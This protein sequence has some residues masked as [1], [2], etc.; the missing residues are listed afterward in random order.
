MLS[1]FL[2]R[3]ASRVGSAA[4]LFLA[5][6]AGVRAEPE[7]RT[8]LSVDFAGNELLTDAYLAG[9]VRLGPGVPFRE[10][11]LDAAVKDLY[12]VG[13]TQIRREIAEEPEGVRVTLH[14]TETAVLDAARQVGCPERIWKS[15][16]EESGLESGRFVYRTDI[17]E[18]ERRIV[19]ELGDRRYYKASVREEI[20]SSPRGILVTFHV[21]TGPKGRVVS[22]K[23]EGN[24]S[25][26]PGRIKKRAPVETRARFLFFFGG[27]YD[28]DEWEADLKRIERYYQSE[29]WLDAKVEGKTDVSPDGKKIRL[30]VRIEEG[31]RYTLDAFTIEQAGAVI[32]EATLREKVKSAVGEPY[33]PRQ[34]ESDV[35]KIRTAFWNEGYFRANVRSLPVF[36]VERKRVSVTVTA[37]SGEQVYLRHLDFRGN[38]LTRDKVL[39]REFYDVAPGGLLKWGH[40]RDGVQRLGFLNFFEPGS[41]VPHVQDTEDP[42]KKDVVVD[43]EEGK[44][45]QVS[46][47]GGITSDDAVFASFLYRQRNF[48]LFRLW[49]FPFARGGGQDLT[50]RLE[51]GTRRSQ[52]ELS[53][54]EPWFFNYPVGFGFDLYL[55]R[56][57]FDLYTEERRGGS[58]TFSRRF[59]RRFTLGLTGKPERIQIS[60]IEPEAPPTIQEARGTT[61]VNSL[62]PFFTW[63][64]RDHPHIPT[65]GMRLEGS[66]EVAGGRLGGV[67]FQKV[68]SEWSG[69]VPVHEDRFERRHVFSAR[70]SGGWVEAYSRTAD[71]PIFERFFAGGATT[72]RGFDFRTVS[73]RENGEEVGGDF[74]LLSNVEYSFPLLPEEDFVRGALFVDRGVVARHISEHWSN[75]FRSSWGAGLRIRIP[76]FAPTPIQLDFAWPMESEEGDRR[77]VFSFLFSG[78]F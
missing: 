38:D 26:S 19:K 74:R 22:V 11:D 35:D 39:R 25:L 32:P 75:E 12:A 37:D 65:E 10:A 27:K 43:V 18:V 76:G 54:Y 78:F 46:I 28:A 51:P 9:R 63:D 16:M 24:E 42:L 62:I 30:T 5:V 20:T 40:I 72:I 49:D 70:L 64:R 2:L 68:L 15:V 71:V 69:H 8:I 57:I 48:D 3:R 67:D 44:T 47:G 50:L 52:Y 55:R 6:L 23:Y 34:M 14:V 56:R 73:P 53:F 59:T 66:Y 4:V 29:G 31:S 41:I 61:K 60:D 7:G 58:M 33:V 36:D 13:I 77:Q 21:E 45:G 1:P 17:A